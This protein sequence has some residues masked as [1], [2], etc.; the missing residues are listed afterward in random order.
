MNKYCTKCGTKLIK[1]ICPKCTGMTLKQKN[2]IRFYNI[3]AISGL[4]FAIICAICIII[5][6]SIEKDPDGIVG[7]A[8][9]ASS[10]LAFI[11]TVASIVLSYGSFYQNKILYTVV[12]LISLAEIGFAYYIFE[13]E[14][15][16]PV[17]ECDG[18][19]TW[20]NQLNTTIDWDAH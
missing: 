3:T 14:L 6:F 20:C 18:G 1:K 10:I 19:G 7:A 2:F 12:I 11:S 17:D 5:Y 13:K 15:H 9:T 8:I 4:I 16:K